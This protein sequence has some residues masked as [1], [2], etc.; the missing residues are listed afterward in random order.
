MAAIVLRSIKGSPLTTQEVDDNFTNLSIEIGTKL[1]TSAYTASDILT[2]LKSV[3]TDDSGLNA[4][5]LK[6]LNVDSTNTPST[7]VS[8]D[9]SGNFAA[10]TITAN[11][12]GNVQGVV[13]GSLIGNATNITG[14]VSMLNGG[15]GGSSPAQALT[16]LLP[17]GTVNGYVLKTAGPGS[18]YWAAETGSAQQSG[19]RVNT[20]RTFFTATANQTEF[21]GV[22]TYTPGAGQ[23]RIYIDGV[24][25]FNSAYTETSSTSFTLL[26][27][28]VAGTL[29]MAEVDSY[30]NYNYTALDIP[31]TPT[32]STSATNVQNALAE[33]DTEKAAV[34]Q[35]MFLG[36]TQVAINRTSGALTL[37]GVSIDGNAA[38]ATNAGNANNLGG[39][40]AA[41]Y[42]LTENLPVSGFSNIQIFTS[43]G[44]F[45]VPDGI[46]K[47]KVTVVGAGG[48]GG[49]GNSGGA[50]KSGGSGGSAIAILSN[51]SSSYSI[52]VGTGGA[53][54]AGFTT[55]S[56]GTGGTSSF[57]A[58]VSATGGAGGA[59]QNGAGGGT[60]GT[61]L[62]SSGQLIRI[63]N[64]L[65]RGFYTEGSSSNPS[66]APVAYSSDGVF[67]AGVG[68]YGITS[69]AG[70]GGVGGV[71]IVEY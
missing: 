3:D 37:A 63:L 10:G 15:T 58:A 25:Q 2:K 27:G 11:L 50:G 31:C 51:L 57:G 70:T 33:L 59:W 1:N 69:S 32:G 23:L 34:G 35:Q 30:V 20:S 19:T 54:A 45:T 62:V 66:Q 13:T 14:I 18:Y 71:V 21:T 24:R 12:I 61:G 42:A 47:L 6:S 67:A 49:S 39:I 43:S 64:G 4:T 28:V 60:S 56:G 26:E 46:T 40:P 55:Q 44:I 5:T 38:T 22:G 16:N 9:T 17:S 29:I 7:V 41:S 36:T 52:T 48:G 65:I 68:G 53:G 8:R